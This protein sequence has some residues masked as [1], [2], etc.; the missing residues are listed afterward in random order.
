MKIVLTGAGFTNKGAE[1]MLLTVVTELAKRIPAVEFYLYRLR[2]S[3]RPQ[4][5]ARGIPALYWPGDSTG[6]RLGLRWWSA[7]ELGIK[8]IAKTLGAIQDSERLLAIAYAEYLQR[9]VGRIDAVID[10]SGFAYGDNW[11]ASRV[12]WSGPLLECGL[13][14]PMPI[15]YL[16]QAWGAFEESDVRDATLKLLAIDGTAFFSRD[17]K[18]SEYLEELLSCSSGS[19]RVCPDI[20]FAFDGGGRDAGEMV[21]AKMGCSR[22]RPIVGISPNMQIYRR[23]A[24]TGTE[25]TYVQGI[26]GFVRRCLDRHDVD[27]VLQSNEID[28]FGETADDRYLC[29]LIEESVDGSDRV[30]MTRDVLTAEQTAGLIGCF[31]YLIGSRFHS[32]VFALSQGVACTALGWSPK[33]SELLAAFGMKDAVLDAENVRPG[34]LD[35]CFD[36]GWDQRDEAR[37]R[38]AIVGRSMRESIG[39]LFDEVAVMVE[40]LG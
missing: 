16:P 20:V 28:A 15:I 5:S 27:I 26:S 40:G 13:E 18:S 39:R 9:T 14:H 32:L 38:I 33:Y 35:S 22:R 8:R 21:L 29:G 36:R 34:V 2:I 1:A 12:R 6:G 10:I 19:I 23:T 31:D 30:L 24:G 11:G 4:A 7:K 17:A 25:N 3:E 37:G